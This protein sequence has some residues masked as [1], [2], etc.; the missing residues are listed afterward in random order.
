MQAIQQQERGSLYR[1]DILCLLTIFIS[2]MDFL[3]IG[4]DFLAIFLLA[5]LI[6]HIRHIVIT[7]QAILL[8][9]FSIFYFIFYS[10]HNS[11][12]F[13]DLLK[14]LVMPWACYLVGS[15]FIRNSPNRN[16]LLLMIISI[17]A[18]FFL[19][20]TLNVVSYQFFHRVDERYAR[21]AYD[22]WHKD[23][24]SVTAQG[25]LFLFPTAI[26]I[27]LLF[28]GNRKWTIPSLLVLSISLYNA[29]QQAYRAFFFVSGL[30]IVG[31]LIYILFTAKISLRRRLHIILGAVILFLIVL[32]V[33]QADIAHLKSTFV[34]TRLYRRITQGDLLNAGGRINIWKSFFD[35]WL[36]YPF[37]SNNQFVLYGGQ[38]YAHNFWLDI[39]RVAG[40]LPFIFSISATIDEIIILFRF[41]RLHTDRS[42]SPIAFCFTSAAII[43]FMVE[44]IYIANPY[45]YYF[46]LMIQGGINGAMHQS[47]SEVTP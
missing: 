41:G 2:S 19:H 35:N 26:S 4:G 39:Y 5:Y 29:I 45:I 23:Y 40:I 24:L 17:S 27:C 25:L 10:Y 20:G 21:L 9:L 6:L 33:W 14:Y 8:A 13:A 30:L 1:R 37:G 32:I 22:F 18:G 36:R 46:F 11:F 43:N 7:Q 3:G 42:I 15:H 31:I 38:T 12:V 47:K 16:L 28:F 44:P 34:S